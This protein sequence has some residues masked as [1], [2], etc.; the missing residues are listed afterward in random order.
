MTYEE[1]VLDVFKEHHN[2]MGMDEEE[3][4]DIISE[5]SFSR[6]EKWLSAVGYDLSEV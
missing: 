2:C 1:R 5:T 3:I 6:I 4:Q